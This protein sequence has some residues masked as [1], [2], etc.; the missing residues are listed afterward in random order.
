MKDFVLLLFGKNCVNCA[1]MSIQVDVYH[2]LWMSVITVLYMRK[3][4]ATLS[5]HLQTLMNFYISINDHTKLELKLKIG[6]QLQK[7]RGWVKTK[8]AQ[9]LVMVTNGVQIYL[10]QSNR[11]MNF[12][13]LSLLT[14]VI[15]G[16]I[17]WLSGSQKMSL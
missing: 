2:A 9:V 10:S 6:Y 12:N 13:D 15:G 1:E 3:R 7:E 5:R 4:C 16:G 11:A 8:K 14:F 17:T